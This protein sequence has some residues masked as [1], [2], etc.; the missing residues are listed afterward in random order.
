MFIGK[1]RGRI[2]FS[3]G[4]LSSKS[5]KEI[6][7]SSGML[8]IGTGN[9]MHGGKAAHKYTSVFNMFLHMDRKRRAAVAIA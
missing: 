6:L 7:K 2:I 4:V 3:F 5:L 1:T 9:L 8:L